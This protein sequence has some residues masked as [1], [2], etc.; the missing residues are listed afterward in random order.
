VQDLVASAHTDLEHVKDYLVGDEKLRAHKMDSMTPMM[1]EVQKKDLNKDGKHD[2]TDV[3]IARMKASDMSDKEAVKKGED[4]A[5]K[6]AKKK[7]LKH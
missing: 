4:A 3:M 2:F 1:G 7:S 6:A 5:K